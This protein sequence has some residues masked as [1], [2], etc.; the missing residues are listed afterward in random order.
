M[1]RVDSQAIKEK[2]KEILEHQIIF[3]LRPLSK[4]L[5]ISPCGELRCRTEIGQFRNAIGDFILR[6][7][8]IYAF[9]FVVISG[10]KF[11]I[12]VVDKL[13]VDSLLSS[14]KKM[15]GAFT[16]EGLGAGVFSYGRVH[17]TKVNFEEKNPGFTVPLCPLD[18]VTLVV[19]TY[20]GTLGVLINDDLIFPKL[21]T[22]KWLKEKLMY[23]AVAMLG[24]NARLKP[25]T[26]AL[27]A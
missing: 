19:N 18:V 22:E 23:P 7:N 13:Y 26:V 27:V 1:V 11:K 5:T 20:A 12:G 24:D 16:E 14:N 15:K 2:R 25:T 3:R 6:P 9:S 21:I 8:N 4:K 17:A 10:T